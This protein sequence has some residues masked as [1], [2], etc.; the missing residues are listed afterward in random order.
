VR[1]AV[2]QDPSDLLERGQRGRPQ[3]V[4]CYRAGGETGALDYKERRGEKA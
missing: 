4:T 2:G 3:Q 1:E